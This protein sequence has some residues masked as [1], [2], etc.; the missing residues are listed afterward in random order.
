MK[1][2][3]KGTFKAQSVSQ[4]LVNGGVQMQQSKYVSQPLNLHVLQQLLHKWPRVQVFSSREPLAFFE[5]V[6]E[7]A[8]KGLQS[9][10]LYSL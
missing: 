6:L 2:V 3:Q 7:M 8:T 4:I 1:M 5:L 9:V 10:T